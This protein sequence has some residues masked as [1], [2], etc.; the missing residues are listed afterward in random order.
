VPDWLNNPIYY[1]N[2]GNTTFTGESAT[3]GDFFGLDDVMTENPRVV[4]GFIDIFSSWID[5]YKIDGFRIDTEKHVNSG[6]WRAFIP[7]ILARARKDG[8]PNFHIFG[9]VME[10]TTNMTAL[11]RHTHT[12]K[13]PAVMDYSLA[14]ALRETVAGTA[15]TNVF[16]RLFANDVLYKGGASAAM[17]NATFTG[18]YDIGRFAYF[19]RQAFP[20]ASDQE[21]MK[22]VILAYAM[23][24][25]MRGVPVI[26]YG[27]EQGFAGLGGDQAARQD[28]LPSAVASYNHDPLVGTTATTAD[29]NFDTSHPIFRAIA[30]LAHL[31]RTHPALEYG[32]QIIRDYSDKPGL[33]AL[34][35]IDPKTGGEVLVAFNTSTKPLAAEVEVDARTRHFKSV[36][37]HCARTPAAPGSYRVKIG[38]LGYVICAAGGGR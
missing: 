15:G 20:K 16:A 23:V 12:D 8:I 27:D 11:A 21:V 28:M 38:P 3:M 19:V 10:T 5:K 35:R 22:R 25:T 1:H 4:R 9:E 13:L 2:R 33:L 34:S 37:G 26:Y 6:F 29:S 24:L 36:M 17:G 18:N 31:R 14:A 32:R 30:K 7:A